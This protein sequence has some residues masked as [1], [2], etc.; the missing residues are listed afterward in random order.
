MVCH[1]SYSLPIQSTIQ[2][3]LKLA[4]Q[5]FYDIPSSL[6]ALTISCNETHRHEHERIT[7]PNARTTSSA[8]RSLPSAVGT[9]YRMRSTRS[10]FWLCNQHYIHR[11]TN[12]HRFSIGLLCL[13]IRFSIRNNENKYHQR[14]H[15]IQYINPQNVMFVQRVS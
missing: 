15:T 13:R 1:T 7:Y 4:I 14:V 10:H 8:K 2:T 6:Y 3:R 5:A 11:H 12:P 9:L